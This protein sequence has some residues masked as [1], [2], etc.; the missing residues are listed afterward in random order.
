MD[1]IVAGGEDVMAEGKRL[2]ETSVRLAETTARLQGVSL[3]LAALLELSMELTTRHEAEH[4]LQI[5]AAAA[6]DI[7]GARYAGLGMLADDGRSLRH[8]V[9]LGLEEAVVGRV[10]GPTPAEG[11]IGR[12][13]ADQRSVRVAGRNGEVLDELPSGHPAVGSFLGVPILSSQGTLGWFYLAEKVGGK[14]FSDDDEQITATLA[15]QV[16]VAYENARLYEDLQRHAAHLQLEIAERNRAQ[17]ALREREEG[18]RQLESQLIQAQ[19]MEAVGR[20]AGGVAHDFNNLLTVILGYSELLARQV[21][22]DQRLRQEVEEIRG[23]AERAAG[24]TSQLLAFSRRQ[25]I[26]PEVLDLNA[27]ISNLGKMLCRLIGE[28]VNLK[29]VLGEPVGRVRADAG[30]IEQVIMNLA[31]NSRDAMPAGGA[32]VIETRDVEVD[33]TCASDHTGVEPG[34]F[35]VLEVADTGVGMDDEV[36]S[37]LFE[38]FFTT[39]EM[40]KGTGL[41]LATVYGIVKQSGGHISVKSEPGRGTAFRIYLPRTDDSE[42][43]SP[44][45]FATDPSHVADETLL[46]AED[47]PKI[48]KLAGE[49]LEEAGYVTLKARSAEQ[50]LDLARRHD[51]TIHLL[52][53]D[54]V[55]PEMDGARLAECL[56]AER[57]CLRTLYMSGYTDRPVAEQG[58]RHPG[59]VLLRKPFTPDGLLRKVREVLDAPPPSGP[60]PARVNP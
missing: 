46:V 1:S 40:G 20:L 49:I 3:R 5:F 31:V 42:P 57:P 54:M 51:G 19:K 37:H 23:A 12:I 10:G 18:F 48:L 34:S 28:D 36:L 22:D 21:A 26:V 17:E 2:G 41:G 11:W 58:Q 13:L 14:E 59:S 9:G 52:L 35:V 60:D 16:A 50:A 15:A 38:P 47:D 24:L 55:M 27:V 29:T 45:V 53:T 6:R 43:S 25:V 32:L 7:V 44:P 56:A 8:L 4:L 33:D 39:K 30:Q